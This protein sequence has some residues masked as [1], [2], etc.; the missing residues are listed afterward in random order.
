MF[1]QSNWDA[2]MC[3]KQAPRVGTGANRPG[4]GTSPLQEGCTC[5]YDDGVGTQGWSFLIGVKS[6]NMLRSHT[7]GL[8]FAC[9]CAYVYNVMYIHICNMMCTNHLV[10]LFIVYQIHLMLE[11][12]IA[13][14]LMISKERYP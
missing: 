11:S 7:Y 4:D 1:T 9:V 6:S 13:S 12:S 14:E 5:R 8:Y 3:T 2:C 10:L